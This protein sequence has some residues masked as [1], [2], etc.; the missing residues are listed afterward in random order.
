VYCRE[1]RGLLVHLSWELL[2]NLH[3]VLDCWKWHHVKDVYFFTFVIENQQ[4]VVYCVILTAVGERVNKNQ[5]TFRIFS[6]I[7]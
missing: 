4:R 2:V 5:Q 1:Y 6:A 7:W 3:F